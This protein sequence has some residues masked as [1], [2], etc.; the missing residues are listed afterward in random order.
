[1]EVSSNKKRNTLVNIL[2]QPP[3][4]EIEPFEIFLNNV[5]TKNK[6]TN[7]AM[8]IAGDFNLNLPDHNANRKYK[9]FSV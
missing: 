6:N 2:Y 9:I 8:H 7:K 3:N 5:F 1:M 4:R